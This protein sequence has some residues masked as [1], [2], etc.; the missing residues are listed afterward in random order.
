MAT[1]EEV[2]KLAAL[3]R[4]RVKETELD[5]FTSEFDSILAYIGQLEKLDLPQGRRGEK[6]ALRNVMR[7]DGEP[8]AAG[9]YTKKLVAQFRAREG[10]ALSVKQII[11]HE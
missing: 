1:R 4:V 10:D 9:A 3:A 7:E 5:T 2:T 11:S 6:P 8:H